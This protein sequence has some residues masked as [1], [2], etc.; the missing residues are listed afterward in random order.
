[1]GQNPIVRLSQ[2]GAPGV[3]GPNVPGYWLPLLG[4]VKA[5]GEHRTAKDRGWRMDVGGLVKNDER[6]GGEETPKASCPGARQTGCFRG[7]L[8]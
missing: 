7:D 1:M 5:H 6:D 2:L 4:M 8:D 3:P